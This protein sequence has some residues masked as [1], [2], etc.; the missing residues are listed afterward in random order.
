MPFGSF[1]LR[2]VAFFVLLALVPLSVVSW[3]F[4]QLAARNE[5]ERADSHLSTTVRVAVAEY[6]RDVADVEGTARSIAQT[7]VVQRGL[8]PRSESAVIRLAKGLKNAALYFHG[9]LLVGAPSTGLAVKRTAPIRAEDGELLGHVTVW[10]PLDASLIAELRSGSGLGPDERLVLVRNGRILAGPRGFSGELETPVERPRVLAVGGTMYIALAGALPGRPG[11]TVV[12]LTPKSSV[13]NAISQVRRR[14]LA[15]AAAA[16][17][18]AALLAYMLGRTTVRSLKE[19]SEAAG[20][21]ARGRFGRRVTVRGRDELAALTR[22]FNDMAAQLAARDAEL[23]SER[24]RVTDAIARFGDALAATHDPY[25]LLPV[26]VEST[27]QATGAV[28]GRLLF[29]E[30]EIVSGDPDAGGRPLE[31]PLGGDER[32][33]AVL[34]LMPVGDDFTDEA[35]ERAY[36][37]GKQASIALE[38]ARLHR[39]LARQAVTDGLTE[40]ANRRQFEEAL[41][42]EVNR[43]ERFG[44]SLALIF[45]DLDDFK[46]VNDRYGH[47]AGDEV[48]RAFARVLRAALREIDLPGRFGGDEFAVLLPQTDGEGGREV[49]ERLRQAL[50]ARPVQIPSRELLAVTASFGVASFPDAPTQAALLAAADEALYDAKASGKGC[51][52]LAPGGAA[53]A[54]DR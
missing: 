49:A 8:E 31:I 33:T 1:K 16:L 4:G 6:R 39:R 34:L 17:T 36:W 47:Q 19:L 30:H 29:D 54:G 45:A 51:V 44:G 11:G 13:D 42:S 20:E 7:L 22:A 38:N 52:R 50:A 28:G 14:L 40:L 3:A 10:L 41:E 35:R 32:D 5:R 24:T 18:V 15:L 48:L 21:F 12:A 23:H 25:T 2:L 27:V 26:I 46:Q 43:V 53:V 37:L 9:R